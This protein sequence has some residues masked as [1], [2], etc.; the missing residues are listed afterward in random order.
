MQYDLAVAEAD[1]DTGIGLHR[2]RRSL[3]DVFN[4]PKLLGLVFE[5]GVNVLFLVFNLSISNYYGVVV[6]FGT[7]VVAVAQ[8]IFS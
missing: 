7:A 2:S 8:F 4:L 3:Q 1:G 5:V 6:Y